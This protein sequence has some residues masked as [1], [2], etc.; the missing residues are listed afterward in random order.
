MLA[1][2]FK[3]FF[4]ESPGAAPGRAKQASHDQE[5]VSQRQSRGLEHFFSAIRGQAGL[6][7][8]DLGG[9]V[10]ENVDF[11]TEQGHRLTAQALLASLDEIFG[12]DDLAEQGNPERIQSFIKQNFDFPDGTFDG[13][14]LWDTLQYMA[15]PLLN[16]TVQELHRITREQSYLLGFFNSDEKRRDSPNSKF[17]IV[18]ANTLNL[19]Q[20]GVRKNVQP[21]NN[22]TLEKIFE[23]FDS[24]KFFLTKENLREVIVRR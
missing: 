23:K 5:A 1:D 4:G 22:R 19:T 18:Q 9:A 8:L 3:T 6:A 2:R 21:F 13:I 17:R 15:L 16:A 7:I 10:Q 14:L 12:R 20:K 11:I 24:V